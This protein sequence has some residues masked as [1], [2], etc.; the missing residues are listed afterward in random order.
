MDRVIITGGAAGIGNCL[1]KGY[2]REGYEV[3]VFDKDEAQ[4]ED[5]NIH[6]YKGDLCSENDIKDFFK[7]IRENYGQ[8]NIL[9]NNG[10]IS[11]FHKSIYDISISDF[12]KVI[13]TNLRGAFIFAKEFIDQSHDISYGR[14]INIA[15]VRYAQNEKGWEAYGASKGALVS[16]TNTLCL[17]LENT[18]ITVNAISPGWICT[19]GY[20]DLTEINHVQHPSGRVGKPED[21]LNA[22]LFLSKKESD[23]INGINLVVDGGKGKELIF[24]E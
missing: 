8:V 5:K 24:I 6:F 19:E 10:A 3:F 22:C 23:F 20:E 11:K 14:I 12:D 18:K 2:A 17:S 4:F 9:I 7:D 16:L 1:A 21:I 13:D 15:S